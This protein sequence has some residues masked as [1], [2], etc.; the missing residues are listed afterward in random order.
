MKRILGLLVVL[1]VLN[2]VPITA[3]AADNPP[4]ET[5]RK[6]TSQVLYDKQATLV[7]ERTVTVEPGL[8]YSFISANNLDVTGFTALPTFVL[9]NIEIEKIRRDVLVPS[10]TVRFGLS[11]AFEFNLRIPY[12]LRFDR[13]NRGVFP[14]SVSKRVEEQD[15]GDIEGGVLVHLLSEKGDRPQILAGLRV[16][17]RTGKEPYGLKTEE[18]SPGNTIPAELPTGSGH[19][20][21]EPSL[22]FV[23]TADPAVFF[24]TIGYFAHLERDTGTALRT[25]DPGDSINYSLGV[26]YALNERFALSTSLEQ[27]FFGRTEAGGK[28]IAETDLTTGTLQ[29]GGTYAFSDKVSL[30]LSVGV[31]LTPDSPDLQVAI[32]TPIRY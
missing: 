16:K 19:W 7:G 9:G 26:A 5:P 12:V 4:G 1:Q 24:A 17:S 30:S 31:G 10:L 13:F 27:K 28:K 22:S 8:E 23:K 18:I 25:I 3:L 29:V 6:V 32:K 15:L 2:I 20:G 14:D 21:I 11:D